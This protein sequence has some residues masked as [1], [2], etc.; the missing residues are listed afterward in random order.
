MAPTASNPELFWKGNYFFYK[1]SDSIPHILCLWDLD[2]DTLNT[3][4]R[5]N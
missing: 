2:G 4:T 3:L 1:G 5:Y